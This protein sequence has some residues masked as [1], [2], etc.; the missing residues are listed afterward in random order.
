[1]IV[2]P[3]RGHAR[4]GAAMNERTGTHKGA[5]PIKETTDAHLVFLHRAHARLILVE[6]GLISLDEAVSNF[7]VT[8]PCACKGGSA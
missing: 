5:V 3:W 4:A 8:V 1:M 2:L 7:I 6:N